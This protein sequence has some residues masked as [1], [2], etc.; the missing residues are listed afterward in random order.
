MKA[1]G[2]GYGQWLCQVQVHRRGLAEIRQGVYVNGF[3]FKVQNTVA[4]L[5]FPAFSSLS[6]SRYL[7][8][9]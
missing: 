2:L 3:M 1:D 5:I 9:G 8:V 7:W 4:S 6:Q